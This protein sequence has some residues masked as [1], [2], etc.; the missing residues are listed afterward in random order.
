MHRHIRSSC[1]RL[2]ASLAL[3]TA[4]GGAAAAQSVDPSTGLPYPPFPD[5]AASFASA[6]TLRCN[7]DWLYPLTETRQEI[8]PARFA[9]QRGLQ[10]DLTITVAAFGYCEAGEGNGFAD[11]YAPS[12]GPCSALL[13]LAEK[14]DFIASN[15]F[16]P[17]QEEI[18]ACLTGTAA[19]GGDC[20]GV[21]GQLTTLRTY[22]EIIV[23]R[24][25]LVLS[26]EVCASPERNN[27]AALRGAC[28][29]LENQVATEAAPGTL[30]PG[31]FSLA[32]PLP[33]L[34]AGA[35]S[36]VAVLTDG[37]FLSVTPENFVG[38]R[39]SV[40]L[41]DDDAASGG[42]KRGTILERQSYMPSK[43]GT[44]WA[45]KRG[46]V[47]WGMCNELGLADVNATSCRAADIYIDE[48]GELHLNTPLT[49]QRQRQSASLCVD[50][51]DFHPDQPLMMTVGLEATGSVPERLWPGE[52]MEIGP[53]LDRKVTRED[54]LTLRVFGK[55]HGVSLAE[56]LRINGVTDVVTDKDE[57]CRMARSWVPVVDHEIPIGDPDHQA[58]IPLS[59]GRGRIGETQRVEEGDYVLLWVKDIEPSGSVQVEYAEGQHVGYQ[60]P[61]LLGETGGVRTPTVAEPTEQPEPGDTTP[62]PDDLMPPPS[63][64]SNQPN[65]SLAMR[66]AAVEQPL[67]P[68]RARYPGS[69]VLRLGSPGGNYQYSL[70]VCTR[71]G[72]SA[73][74]AGAA[75]K[76]DTGKIIVD[77]K[78]FVHGDYHF[79]IRLYFGYTSFPTPSYST[80]EIGPNSFEV[81]ETSG[82]TAEYDVAL[83]LAAYPF[84]RDP[85]NFSYNPL[86]AAYWKS[87]ALLAGFTLRNLTSP[88]DDFYLGAGLP[89]ANGV[90]LTGLAHIGLRQVPLDVRP[91]DTFMS[92][93]SNPSIDAEYP[94]EDAIAVGL[95]IGL[96]FDYDLFERAFMNIWDRLAGRKY[97]SASGTAATRSAPPGHWRKR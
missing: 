24:A 43:S 84:G 82:A 61:P 21:R 37:R 25:E 40:C 55:A 18:A 54:V 77:E 69:R 36:D 13:K 34:V 10:R 74:V 11:G 73:T 93:E 14:I 97:F 42:M 29:A 3:V 96:S 68:R 1:I 81:V 62:V 88:W 33:A 57:A 86:E 83:L 8:G 80:R 63:P 50:V 67:L 65:T 87:T 26:Y 92:T 41:F 16:R 47:V 76:C 90:S 48:R 22:D 9:R 79:G 66:M 19:S 95:S 28:E 38:V 7:G 31:Q 5:A 44:A 15:L 59:F 78:L 91:G 89:V 64:P 23:D 60:P 35:V 85:R 46:A 58:V 56:V 75:A 71:T 4:A 27:N 51:S 30:N 12:L 45:P 2:I 52:T 6:A 72:T 17:D 32:A 94:V 39:R 20:E 53:L 70:K 49:T